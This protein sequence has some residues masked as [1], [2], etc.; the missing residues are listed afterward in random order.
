MEGWARNS[1]VQRRPGVPVH[2]PTLTQCSVCG[3]GG[4]DLKGAGRGPQGVQS[5]DISRHWWAGGLESAWAARALVITRQ[6]YGDSGLQTRQ[7]SQGGVCRVEGRQ[8]VA[9]GDLDGSTA[10]PGPDGRGMGSTGAAVPGW[11]EA[12]GF[13]EAREPH[14]KPWLRN[15]RGPRAWGKGPGQD[16]GHGRQV[17]AR[18]ST[19]APPFPACR[20]LIGLPLPIF[21]TQ[22]H[23]SLSPCHHVSGVIYLRGQRCSLPRGCGFIHPRPG[24]PISCVGPLNKPPL[25]PPAPTSPQSTAPHRH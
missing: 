19:A 4:W 20:V 12:H 8:G 9:H 2:L 6:T 22:S 5:V 15:V 24:A 21:V 10:S 17:P 25:P 3:E 18:V 7:D 16:R 1:E 11:E 13:A 14:E 23:P